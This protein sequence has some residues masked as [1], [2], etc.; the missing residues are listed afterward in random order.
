VRKK[1]KEGWK[2]KR[3]ERDREKEGCVY[4]TEI[5]RHASV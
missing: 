1:E 5:E 4:M 3:D 2:R